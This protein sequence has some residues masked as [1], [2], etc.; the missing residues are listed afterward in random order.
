MT[1]RILTAQRVNS[2]T[3]TLCAALIISA[4]A[5]QWFSCSNPTTKSEGFVLP[6]QVGQE[7]KLIQGN[8]GPFGHEGHIAYAFDFIMPMGSVVI[9]ARSGKV[10]KIEQQYMDGT[11]KPG[12]ENYIF[13]QHADSSFSRYYHLTN[14]GVL[15][16]VG[17]F[18]ARGDTIGYSGNS[19]ASAGPHLHFDVTKGCSDWGCRTV[20][21]SFINAVENP[22]QAGK[23]YLANPF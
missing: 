18:V 10:V 20:P 1:L 23:K 4:L 13:I 16:K 7:Y 5:T 22:L 21:V 8:N 17:H 6:F 11:K 14:N 19:G 12:Q 3:R 9:A 2:I 15:V